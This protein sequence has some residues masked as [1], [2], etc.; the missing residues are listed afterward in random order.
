MAKQRGSCVSMSKGA[1]HLCLHEGSGGGGRS[2]EI[3]RGLDEPEKA[4]DSMAWLKLDV[5]LA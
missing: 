2:G 1:V 5:L 3:A 4:G